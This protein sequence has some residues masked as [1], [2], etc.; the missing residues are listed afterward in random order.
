MKRIKY[1]CYYDY[2]KGKSPR[3]GVQSASTKIDYIVQSINKNG[4]AVDLISKSGVSEKGFAFDAGGVI[5]QGGNTIRHFVS[6]GCMGSPLR[7]LSRWL[8]TLHFFI[9]LLFHTHQNEQII[10]YHSLGYCKILNFLRKIKNLCIIGEVEELYQDVHEQS[11]SVVNAEYE[12][13]NGCA[14]YLFPTI[15]MNNKFN[16]S[17]KPFAIVHGIYKIE[18]KLEKKFSDGKIHV[19]YGG[20][21]DPKK[22]GALV[23]AE[24]GRFLPE[25]YVVHICGFGSEADIDRIKTMILDTNANSYSETRFE[26]LLRGEDYTRFIQKCHTGLS[27]QNPTAAFNDTSFPSKILVY[28]ANGLKVVS[29]RIPVVESCAVVDEISF[30][31]VQSPDKIAEAIQHVTLETAETPSMLLDKVDSDFSKSLEALLN[32]RGNNG[33]CTSLLAIRL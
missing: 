2:R 28:L 4:V 22:G 12:F 6:F 32:V 25:N 20:T 27:T 16:P 19:V 33:D 21:F 26:G 10:V 31:D 24:V 15:L 5:Q 9:W 1:F 30:Y 11:K 7:V 8:N 23:A 17:R 18:E 14:K 3:E 29:I 13:I